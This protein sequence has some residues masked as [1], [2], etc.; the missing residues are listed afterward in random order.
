MR[1][2]LPLIF[3]ATTLLVGCVFQTPVNNQQPVD[4]A[5]QDQNDDVVGCPKDLRVCSDGTRLARVAPSC[6]FPACPALPSVY[7][8]INTADL[9]GLVGPFAFSVEVPLGWQVEVVPAIEALNFYLPDAQGS[10]N[11]DKSQIFVRYFTA[12]G[13]LTLSTV[14]IFSQTATTILG[15]PAVVYDIE[16]KSGVTNF[17]SQPFW[18]NQR[19]TVTDIR[20]TD[21][22]PATF[23]VF[24]QRP[25]ID[26]AIVDHFLNSLQFGTTVDSQAISYSL[27]RVTK[28]SFGTYVTPN[29][30]SVQPERFSGYHT[31]IDIEYG[32]VDQDVRVTALADGT[33]VRSGIVSGYGGMVAVRHT[34]D[35][36]EY[37]VVYGHLDPARLV[38]NGTPLQQGQQLGVLGEGFSDETDGERKHLHLSAH[39]GVEIN[40]RGYVDVPAD[41]AQWMDPVV[42]F[43]LR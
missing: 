11:L 14:T 20:E 43:S 37:V 17:S 8:R 13:F 10:S 7:Q 29:N 22:N 15:R 5:T 25:G 18:R 19:H 6:E 16:K 1:K 42:L 9:E 39:K 23:Y 2:L 26:Q 35:G 32:D 4:S 30:S 40:V 33:V 31:G 3:L 21:S 38:G 41:L 34:I 24:S 36:A 27:D 12:N 28:K